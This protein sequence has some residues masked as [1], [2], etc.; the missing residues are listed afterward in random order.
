[1]RLLLA[2]CTWSSY[3]SRRF[4]VSMIPYP[5]YFGTYPEG[6]VTVKDMLECTMHG[7]CAD[8]EVLANHKPDDAPLY[9]FERVFLN[10]IAPELLEDFPKVWC[11]RAGGLL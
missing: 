5:E 11:R 4:P 2:A 3:G 1:M 9:V 6:R 7:R 10:A 8:S